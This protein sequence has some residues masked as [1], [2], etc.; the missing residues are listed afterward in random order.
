MPALYNL[1]GSRLLDE[2][3]TIWGVDHTFGRL[4]PGS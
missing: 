3:T 4:R 1:A 2:T